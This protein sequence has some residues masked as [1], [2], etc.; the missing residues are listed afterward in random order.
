[1]MFR[2][3]GCAEYDHPE[4]TVVFGTAPPPES[5]SKKILDYFQNAVAGGLR[6]VPGQSVSF[7]IHSVRIIDRSDGTLGVTERVGGEAWEERVDQTVRDLLDQAVA[8]AKLGLSEDFSSVSDD[9]FAV[10]QP[11]GRDAST[12]VLDRPDDPQDYVWIVG[13][14][15]DHDHSA[16]VYT[17]LFR[18]WLA[19]PFTAQFLAL[20]PGTRV[21][22]H[23]E[24]MSAGGGIVADVAYQGA[25]LTPDGGMYFGPEPDPAAS[26]HLA[27]IPLGDD[28]YRTRIGSHHGHRDIVFRLSEP[29]V[30]GLQ[31]ALAQW[32]LGYLQDS[33]AEGIR[34]TPDQTIQVGWRVLRV[35]ER[36]DGTLGLHERTAGGRWEEHVEQAL[37]DLWF[38]KEVVASVGLT[39]RLS[40]PAEKQSA[41]VAGCADASDVALVL[42]R[43]DPDDQS[44]SG[45]LVSCARD[46]R[47]P[48]WVSRP[49]ADLVD[50]TPFASQFLALPVRSS[51]TVEPAHL[52]SS[53]RIGAQIRV[54]GRDLSPMVGSYLA[55]LADTTP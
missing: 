41:Y 6:F 53:G 33:I 39:D 24:R 49:L 15:D 54:D 47:H 30:P 4:F 36:N 31:D 25:M 10:V 18:V 45:W 27:E 21:V 20:P 19:F 43:T 5:S 28:W 37:R 46:H 48:D 51:V 42:S 50:S 8:A 52:T 35:V 1:M 55:A 29:P 13:C 38:Q 17:D 2:T 9:D 34:F 22:V 23:R 26:A 3:V 44:T 11:C 32:L 40:F 7:G 16:W 14:G 12:L